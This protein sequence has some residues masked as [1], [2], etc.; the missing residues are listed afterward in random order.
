[1]EKVNPKELTGGTPQQN[2]DIIEDLLK[3]RRNAKREI[4][5]V[6]AAPAFVATG[7]AKTLKEGYEQAEKVLDSGAA[8]EKLEKLAAFTNEGSK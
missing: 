5:L 3:G 2:A 7:K 6:N 8:H 4:V 1:M